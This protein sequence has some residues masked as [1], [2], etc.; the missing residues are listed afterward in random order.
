MGK[1]V[2]QQFVSL[3]GF[4]ANDSGEFTVY[5]GVEGGSAQFDRNNLAWLQKVDA[6][7]FGANTYRMFVGYWPEMTAEREI[8]APRINAL[9]KFVFSGS[10][11]DAP[12]GQHAPAEIE[13]GDAVDG[14]LRVK[15]QFAGD[16]IVW[17][18]LDLTATLFEADVVDTVR[19]VVVPSILGSGKGVFPPS[20]AGSRLRLVAAAAF[21][22]TVVESEYEVVRDAI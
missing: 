15:R 16:I 5:D 20:F 19:L 11:A 2:V 17:G 4:A 13:R 8:V 1:L 6:I 7:V 14:V 9:P 12:W 10:L 3:D 21:D 18:S 22:D